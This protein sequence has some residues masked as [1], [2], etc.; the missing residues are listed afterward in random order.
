VVLNCQNLNSGFFTIELT[1][2]SVEI[3]N[4]EQPLLV[5]LFSANISVFE[6]ILNM[7]VTQLTIITQ[8]KLPAEAECNFEGKVSLVLI[9]G[10]LHKYLCHLKIPF[11]GRYSVQVYVHNRIISNG[12]MVNVV[13]PFILSWIHPSVSS[14]SVG[15]V[16]SIHG[17][18]FFNMTEL[19]CWFN[20]VIV[21]AIFSSPS[22]L[23][24][25]T[26]AWKMPQIVSV[27]VNGR[28]SL[29]F[30]FLSP[31]SIQRVSPTVSLVSTAFMVAV[32]ADGLVQS[33][34]CK[35]NDI[36]SICVLDKLGLCICL[37]VKTSP[38]FYDLHLILPSESLFA[39]IASKFLNLVLLFM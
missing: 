19:S 5:E 1:L 35:V 38:G 36:E 14:Q 9:D 37:I 27:S 34:I 29:A 2:N 13:Q 30:E 28:G 6:T 39:Y 26:P 10:S 18:N 24:C 11:P 21:P 7:P 3:T 4:C 16:V 8:T 15:I 23:L 25:K 32:E 31:L 20:D 33:A 17:S 12:V 22:E